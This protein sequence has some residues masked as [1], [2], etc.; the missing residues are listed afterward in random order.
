MSAHLLDPCEAASPE[1]GPRLALC[2]RAWRQPAPDATPCAS[3]QATAVLLVRKLAAERLERERL[4]VRREL[5]PGALLARVLIGARRVRHELATLR[6]MQAM[7][8][9]RT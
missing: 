2:G 1:A 5:A 6:L 7:R 8:W 3:C 9:W 4:Q